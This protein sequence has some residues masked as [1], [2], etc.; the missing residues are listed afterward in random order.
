MIEFPKKKYKIISAIYPRVS[1]EDQKKEGRSFEAQISKLKKFCEDTDREIYKVYDQDAGRSATVNEDSIYIKKDKDTMVSVFDL[2]KR[3]GFLQMLNDA[4]LGF[5]NEIVIF[6]WDR[7]SR[8]SLFQETALILFKSL[9]VTITPTDDSK[10]PLI[11]KI[12]GN[13]SEE[14]INKLKERINLS[15]QDKFNNGIISTRMPY[16][17]IWDKINNKVLVDNGKAKVV[18]NA[19]EMTLKG[20]KWDEICSELSLAKSTYFRMIK[21]P[22]YY[23]LI[24]FKGKTKMGTH[25]PVISKELFDKVQKLKA[26]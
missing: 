9:G 6:K 25:K 19:F 11:R 1:S 16:A 21:S 22:V 8:N 10:T 24:E 5:F 2:K 20:I 3:P 15:L 26:N 4:E 18:K 12:T 23:G 17:Y 7:F 14:E 13:I